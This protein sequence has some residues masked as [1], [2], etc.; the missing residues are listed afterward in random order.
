MRVLMIDD[1]EAYLSA[2]TTILRGD[3]HDVVGCGTFDEGRLR[4]ASEPFDAVIADVRLGAYN[5]LHLLTLAAGS[6]TKIALSA[7]CDPVIIRDAEHAGARFVLKPSDCASVSALLPPAVP[8][9]AARPTHGAV[10]GTP[11]AGA[12]RLIRRARPP[13]AGRS[14][15]VRRSDT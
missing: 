2:C 15:E 6:M 8:R 14:R 1:D 3:G 12:G 11:R 5:G 13:V 4:L 10:S 7:F 9:A